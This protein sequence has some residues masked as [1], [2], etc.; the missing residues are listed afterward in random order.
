MSKERYKPEQIVTILRQIEVAV[1][2]G[3][4]LPYAADIR[5]GRRLP[6]PRHWIKLA[7]LAGITDHSVWRSRS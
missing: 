1:A 7:Q 2:N 3:V 6:H 5:A 4:S